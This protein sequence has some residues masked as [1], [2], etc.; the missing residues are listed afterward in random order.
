[1]PEGMTVT[2]RSF[3]LEAAS[4]ALYCLKGPFK[5]FMLGDEMGVGK[6]LSGILVMWELRKEPG[7]SLVIC[8]K[9]LCQHWVDTIHNS[10][11]EV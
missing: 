6:T 8:P 3:Q 1:M 2:P 9:N 7:M 5:L 11:E 10:W 4:K